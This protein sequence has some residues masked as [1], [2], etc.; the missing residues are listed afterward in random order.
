MLDA[1]EGNSL[2]DAFVIAG[3]TSGCAPTRASNQF[4]TQRYKT[5]FKTKKSRLESKTLTQ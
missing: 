3:N 5:I 2:V 1:S 4:I